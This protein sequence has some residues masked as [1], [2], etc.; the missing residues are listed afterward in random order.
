VG[1]VVVYL[2]TPEQGGATI[3]PDLGLQVHAHAGHAV[4]FNYD[5]G[6]G[7]V[8]VLHGGAEVQAGEKWVATRW[9][10]E[11]KFA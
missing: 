2:A 6:A 4:F 8:G 1:T 10:R 3:F 5:I 11:K 7:G 9:L